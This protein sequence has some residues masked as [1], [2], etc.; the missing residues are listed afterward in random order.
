MHATGKGECVNNL[1]RQK[2]WVCWKYVSKGGRMT[3][4]PFSFSGRATGTSPDHDKEWTDFVTATAALKKPEQGFDGI[5][6]IMP[7]G[8]FLLDV[9]HKAD[10]DP[11]MKEL[12]SMFPTYLERSPSGNGY[13]FYGQADLSRIPKSWDTEQ[14]RY[15]LDGRYYTKNS[16]LGLELYIGGLTNRFATFTGHTEG[17][18]EQITDCTDAVLTFLERFMKRPEQIEA[19]AEADDRYLRLSEEDI[20]EI[21]V[22]LRSQKNAEKF[23]SLFDDGI[24]PDGLSQSEADASLCAMIAFRT[25]PDHEMIDA[26][27]RE[28]ALYRDKWDR[29]DYAKATI[30][31][32]IRACKGVFHHSL[33]IQPNF[34]LTDCKGRL[35]VSATR[36]AHYVSKHCTYLLV[37]EAQRGSYK[38]YVY[39]DGVYQLYS[40]DRFKG[41]IRQQIADYDR[42]LVKMSVVDEAFKIINT[43]DS[44]LEASELNADE[45]FFN[46]QNGL[47]DIRSLTLKP[48]DPA[49]LSTI[50]I[51]A[52]WKGT[53]D[54]PVF[55]AYLHTLT[56]GDPDTQRLLL[57]FIG[58]AVSNVR[59]SRMKK[60]LFM[61][62]PGDTGKSQLKRLTEMLLGDGNYTGIDL[63]Q[64]EARF[65]TSSIYGRRLAGSSDMSFMT[66]SELK[67]FKKA[68]GGDAL[69]AEFKGQDSFEFV[70]G[71]LLWFCMNELPKF[72]GDDGKWVYDRI[73]PV[74]CPNVIPVSKQDSKLLD[75]LYAE[76]DGIVYKAVMAFKEVILRGY[77]FTEPES[78]KAER[79]DYQAENNSALEFFR[80]FMTKRKG[81]I[82]KN[83][84]FTVKKIYQIY[85][86]WYTT[87]Y[88]MRYVKSQK[89]FFKAIAGYLET[90][91]DE[92]KTR[93][94]NGVYLKDYTIDEDAC[95]ENEV[96]IPLV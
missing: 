88:G 82:A 60:A 25:G 8:Y 89:E 54:T 71:G 5:G 23:K 62:G 53:M 14:Q 47:L 28:S 6:F 57:E 78:T 37:T 84:Q 56:N 72:G 7:E 29:A 68:T 74:Y 96:V 3:K 4:M 31:A 2:I 86:E 38:K 92:M 59:G 83:D 63:Q 45:N 67:I 52:D 55:D 1:K 77:R 95:K 76:R 16:S 81:S 90:S 18:P 20:P 51:R 91:Y 19:V 80:N 21:I 33:R 44:G 93:Y 41:L 75:K 10:D 11:I 39:K 22:S 24:I 64:M 17:R 46:F 40:D 15:K 34:V 73:L 13:H 42:D 50:R 49:V 9:D 26:I 43:E 30:R 27:F 35:Y 48:H 85:D 79:Q 94:G 61:Y 87:N 70:Y 58:A 32:G 69:F 12:I 66:V 65:G 36:L